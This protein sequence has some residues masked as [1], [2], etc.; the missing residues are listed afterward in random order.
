MNDLQHR[1]F[2]RII[3]RGNDRAKFLHNFCTNNIK[4]MTSGQVL[5]AFFVNVQAKVLAHGYVAA[6]EAHHEIWMLPGD[7]A[8]L[9]KHLSRYVISED[10]Q[11]ELAGGRTKA[12]CGQLRPSADPYLSSFVDVEP[13]CGVHRIGELETCGITV[14]WGSQ[15]LTIVGGS[16]EA[17]A[18]FERQLFE[19]QQVEQTEFTYHSVDPLEFE[20]L[21]IGE[22]YPI[23]GTDITSD[24]LAPE[25][26]RN[27]TA[28]SYN[29]GCYLGQEPIARIDALGHVNK[30]LKL[31]VLRPENTASSPAAIVGGKMR[32]S[33]DLTDERNVVGTVTSA[34]AS[35]SVTDGSASDA[36]VTGLSIVRLSAANQ[37]LRLVDQSGHV[38]LAEI[39]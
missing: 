12:F 27:A 10:V 26:D 7:P 34:V 21:R 29:K 38:W 1:E 32:T 31:I 20:T 17:I 8:A 4:A 23:V 33:D 36:S 35:Q 18:A 22:R 24:H 14:S 28:I 2:V 9:V 19:G 25:A 6:F 11:V 37:P 5:E 15:V 3:A 30:S 16:I 13:G 39:Q